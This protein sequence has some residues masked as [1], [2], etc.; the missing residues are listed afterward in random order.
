MRDNLEEGEY[1]IASLPKVWGIKTGLAGVF[2]KSKEGFLVLTNKN[3]FFVPGFLGLGGETKK[4]FA[5]F[6]AHVTKIPNYSESHLDEDIS[7]DPNTWIIPLSSVV[8][9]ES[10][11]IR[12]VS[13][14]RLTFKDKSNKEKNYDFGIAKSTINYP[15]RH[16]LVFENLDWSQWINLIKSH[17]TK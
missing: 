9:V 13:F 11:T 6:Q 17:I 1:I 14:M 3:I 7:E 15:Q 10:V 2:H 4:Y 8:D 16:V 12:K 5:N